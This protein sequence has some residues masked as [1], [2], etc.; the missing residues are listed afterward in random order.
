MELLAV[1]EAAW[2]LKVNPISVDRNFAQYG[3]T[4]LTA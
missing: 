2:I 1:Q 4:I 3:F